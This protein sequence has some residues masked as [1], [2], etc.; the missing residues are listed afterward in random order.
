VEEPKKRSWHNGLPLTLALVAGIVACCGGL[1]LFVDRP[2]NGIRVERL[3]AD[4]NER[5]PDGSSW[6][7]A[8]VWFASH[9]FQPSDIGEHGSKH[10]LYV[11]IPNDSLVET[12]AEI[13][14]ELYFSPEG[15]LEKRVIY[16]FVP[17]F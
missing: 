17:S 9:G 15:R 12:G 3:E 10:G 16:R 6:E 4:L 8:E 2:K 11:I 1:V 13:H 14:I 7:Q 5:L